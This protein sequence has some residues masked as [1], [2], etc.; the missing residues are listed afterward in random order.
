MSLLKTV[1]IET[2]KVVIAV[3]E[4][5][6]QFTDSGNVAIAIVKAIAMYDVSM[7]DPNYKIAKSVLQKLQAHIRELEDAGEQPSGDL[8]A[9]LPKDSYTMRK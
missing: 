8:G 6:C 1:T 5:N 4:D 7:K 9:S 3:R 2:P